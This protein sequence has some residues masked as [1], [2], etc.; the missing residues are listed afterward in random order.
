MIKS[1]AD[2]RGKYGDMKFVTICDNLTNVTYF[3]SKGHGVMNY[4]NLFQYKLDN[5]IIKE[6]CIK[7]S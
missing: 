1:W 2:L 4:I 3:C 5:H 6:Q 7:L